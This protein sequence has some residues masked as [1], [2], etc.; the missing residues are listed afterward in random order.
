MLVCSVYC[1]LYRIVC[2]IQVLLETHY[3]PNILVV[4]VLYLL[5]IY[6]LLLHMSYVL[7]FTSF[8]LFNYTL[9]LGYDCYINNHLG[10][11]I[12]L[13]KILNNNL[14]TSFSVKYIIYLSL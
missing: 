1:E 5:F 4:S 6:L 12:I 14:I 7:T 3:S 11:S 8:D 10:V 13:V 9:L 2:T